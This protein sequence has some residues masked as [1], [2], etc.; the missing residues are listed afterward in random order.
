MA[1]QIG[2]T[3]PRVD[4][5]IQMRELR[6]TA[7]LTIEEAAKTVNGLTYDK[8]RR[9]E[10][11]QSAFRMVGDLRKL[12]IAYGVADD[13]DLVQ[14]LEDLYKAPASQDWTT[15]FRTVLTTTRTFA[16]IE[17]VAQA[18]SVYNPNVIPGQLQTEGYA[19][20]QFTEVQ[21]IEET[22]SEFII[23]NVALRM[24]RR[25]PFTRDEEP[26]KLWAILGEAALRHP[27]GSPAVMRGQ[28]DEILRM[29]A[30]PNVT[31][32]V[33]LTDAPVK[34]L[35]S[36]FTILDLGG[37][38]PTTVQVDTGLGSAMSMSDRP[39]TVARFTR[40]FNSMI[41]SAQPPEETPAFVETL[42]RE[43]T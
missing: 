13:L 35:W 11:G 2:T 38:R 5:G 32:Q 29:A 25:E 24:K 15:Q 21:P 17:S 6:K 8:L 31:I 23:S 20:A 36:N 30:L 18:V 1:K 9:I 26:R 39:A 42:K 10:L 43:K 7:G 27:V 41:A 37:D 12:L 4:L 14:S 34:R 16:G 3:A 40:W 28:Y 33:L 19:H 22:T